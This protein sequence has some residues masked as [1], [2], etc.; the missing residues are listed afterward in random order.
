[1]RHIVAS[2]IMLSSM[3]FPVVASASSSADDAAASTPNLRVST[4]VTVPSLIGSVSIQ[5]PNGLSPH[6]LPMDTQVGLSLTVDS[7]GQPE[8]VKVVKSSNP[9]WDARVVDA[10]QKSHFRPGTVD[11]TPT[12]IELNLLV[13][14]AQ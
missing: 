5:M 9:F 1:M 8:N 12:P 6:F 11:N 4:G 10:I 14:V 3:L 2:T 7:D 13:N